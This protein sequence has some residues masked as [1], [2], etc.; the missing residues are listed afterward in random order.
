MR[1]AI[2]LW[3]WD[4]NQLL[5][6]HRIPEDE[7]CQ[8]C[9]GNG[10]VNCHITLLFVPNSAEKW[11]GK[12]LRETYSLAPEI[13]LNRKRRERLLPNRGDWRVET[14]FAWNILSSVVWAN[15]QLRWWTES[16]WGLKPY[17]L[18]RPSVRVLVQMCTTPRCTSGAGLT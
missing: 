8:D 13:L 9:R 1:T 6:C 12:S 18:W 11:N 17:T 16:I 7:L 5:P 2:H 4:F 14:K 3:V 15:N 10:E